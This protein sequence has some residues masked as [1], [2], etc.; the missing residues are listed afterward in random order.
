V[1]AEKPWMQ[2]DEIQLF[3]LDE[4]NRLVDVSTIS[5]YLKAANIC[6]KRVCS[7]A[8]VPHRLHAEKSLALQRGSGKESGIT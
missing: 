8:V 4:F 5:R 1:L 6:K 2:L 3:L 7:L